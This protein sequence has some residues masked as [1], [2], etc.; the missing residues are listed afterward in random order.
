[1]DARDHPSIN[2][3]NCLK[4]ENRLDQI[5]HRGILKEVGVGVFDHTHPFFI[6]NEL[7]RHGFAGL[8]GRRLWCGDSSLGYVGAGLL[9]RRAL[10]VA[11]T[12]S[13]IIGGF[14][15]SKSE[16]EDFVRQLKAT[17]RLPRSADA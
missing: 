1:M 14:R 9:G 5:L 6:T 12:G 13:D 2:G 15:L 11:S 8:L 16:Y 7:A 17:A 3:K 10:C 4:F